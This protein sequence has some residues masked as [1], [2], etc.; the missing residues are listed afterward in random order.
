MAT[1][2]E[3]RWP[4]AGRNDGHQWGIKVAT[5][6]EKPMAIDTLAQAIEQLDSHR[7]VEDTEALG[8]ASARYFLALR[9]RACPDALPT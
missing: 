5:S 8:D 2:G 9:P 1:G 7:L 4:P 6:G 3:I